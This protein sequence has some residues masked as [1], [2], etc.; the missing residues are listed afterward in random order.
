[1]QPLIGTLN[2]AKWPSYFEAIDTFLIILASQIVTFVFPK[3]AISVIPL[4]SGFT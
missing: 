3:T 1:M 4:K 2:F